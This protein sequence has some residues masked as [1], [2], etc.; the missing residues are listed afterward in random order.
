MVTFPAVLAAAQRLV[1]APLRLHAS[2]PVLAPVAGFTAVFLSSVAAGRVF[3]EALFLVRSHHREPRRAVLE[4]LGDWA[5]VRRQRALLL[6]LRVIH[7]DRT[8]I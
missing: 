1:F 2:V 7:R 4:L 8:S 6:V 3:Y 5:A